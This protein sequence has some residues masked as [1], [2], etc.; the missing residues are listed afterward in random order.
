MRRLARLVIRLLLLL[1]L[2]AVAAAAVIA[3]R[4]VVQAGDDDRRPSD[5]IV[6]LGAAQYNGEPQAYLTARLEHALD[7]YQEGTGS[8]RPR[9]ARHG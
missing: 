3:V 9:P 6:V 8:P 5:A 7:L 1:V 4:I 2:L